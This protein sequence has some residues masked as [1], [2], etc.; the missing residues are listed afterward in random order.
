LLTNEILAEIFEQV[1][2]SRIPDNGDP[3]VKLLLSQININ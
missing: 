3:L 2:L 1:Y